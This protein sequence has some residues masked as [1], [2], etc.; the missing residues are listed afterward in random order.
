MALETAITAEIITL[1]NTVS[2]I[3]EVSNYEKSSFRAFPA[4]TL[5]GSENESEFEATQERQRVYAFNIKLYQEVGSDAQ[6][7]TSEGLVEAERLLRTL[8]DTV[9]DLFDKPANARFSGNADTT[10]EKVILVE[11]VPSVWFYASDRRMRGK[12]I[13]LRVH[14]YLDT[15][16]LT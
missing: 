12:E 13:I 14:T 3:Q 2:A 7:N 11:P 16:L 9:I 6:G 5:V 4:A 10:P 15:N 8:S 1:L